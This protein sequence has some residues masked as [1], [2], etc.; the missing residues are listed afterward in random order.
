MERGR[1]RAGRNGNVV[2]R[3]SE[4]S[5]GSFDLIPQ[6]IQIPTGDGGGEVAQ[7]GPDSKKSC[8][9]PLCSSLAEEGRE[10]AAA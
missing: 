6:G 8:G 5:P 9:G 1:K 10:A 7:L 2:C 4:S 3:S